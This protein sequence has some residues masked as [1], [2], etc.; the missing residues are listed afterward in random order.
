MAR[1]GIIFGLLL[2][3]LTIVGMSVTTQK[4]YTQ[5]VPMMFGIPMLFL[6][7]VSLNPHRRRESVFFALLLSLSAMAIGAGRL[8]VLALEWAAGEYVNPISLRLVLVMTLLSLVFAVIACLW[9]RRRA[10]ILA[11][12]A[13]SSAESP[14]K[15]STPSAIPDSPSS[16]ITPSAPGFSDN[17]YQTPPIVDEPGKSSKP[18]SPG[19]RLPDSEPPEPEPPEPEP[20][21][22]PSMDAPED[23]PQ[24][25]FSKSKST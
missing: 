21:R 18:A 11:P 12:L 5:F 17:P 4:S 8:L 20:S 7:V 19:V 6:G 13:Q 14:S 9:R 1:L 2:C 22:Q 10:K 16:H 15:D 25:P 23:S 3:G 24:P